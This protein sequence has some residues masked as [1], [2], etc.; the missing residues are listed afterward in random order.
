MAHAGTY[1]YDNQA[2]DESHQV[3]SSAARARQRSS[4]L[5][6]QDD[7]LKRKSGDETTR[8][9]ICHP[10]RHAPPAATSPPAHAGLAAHGMGMMATARRARRSCC[11]RHRAVGA[12]LVGERMMAQAVGRA[13]RARSR[14]CCLQLARLRCR[15]G[16]IGQTADRT[17]RPWRERGPS[18]WR[19]A[20]SSACR[21][22]YV[23]RNTLQHAS[24]GCRPPPIARVSARA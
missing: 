11:T 15:Y 18:Y 14:S 10:H 6:T 22:R 5:H 1:M 12:P 8:P 19:I 3:S 17:A 9:Y 24:V 20:R 13:A 21:L 4:R 2:R 23:A 7:R 16:T